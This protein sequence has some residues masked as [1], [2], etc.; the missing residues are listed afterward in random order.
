MANYRDF[1][2]EVAKTAEQCIQMLDNGVLAVECDGVV[3]SVSEEIKQKLDSSYFLDKCRALYLNDNK[4]GSTGALQLVKI[5]SPR[6]M[7]T[8]L[9]LGNNSIGRIGAEG[10]AEYLKSDST[11]TYLYLGENLIGDMAANAF[12]E[13]L[14]VNSTLTELNLWDNTIGEIGASALANCLKTNN[15]LHHFDIGKNQLG[16]NGAVAYAKALAVNTG[17]ICTNIS[18]NDIGVKGLDA[19]TEALKTNTT[20][21]A[22]HS[23]NNP[24]SGEGMK[25]YLKRNAVSQKKA[26]FTALKQ[27]DQ[28]APWRSAKLMIIGNGKAGKTATVRSLL[29]KPFNSNW[30][31]TVGVDLTR[32]KTKTYRTGWTEGLDR[33]SNAEEMAARVAVTKLCA[34]EKSKECST[35]K[36][37]NEKSKAQQSKKMKMS[38]RSQVEKSTLAIPDIKDAL[39]P[40]PGI[41]QYTETLLVQAKKERKCLKFSIWDY[42]GQEVFYTMHH[43]FLTQYGVYVLVFSLVDFLNDE[44]KCLEN[45]NFWLLSVQIH[46]PKAPIVIV[47][48][49]LDALGERTNLKLKTINNCLFS[50]IG[51]RFS[52]VVHNEKENLLFFPLNNK[53]SI[54]IDNVRVAIEKVTSCQEYVNRLVPIKWMH[55]LDAILKDKNCNFI[56]LDLARDIASQHG[57]ISSDEVDEMLHMFHE[58]GLIV[59][60]RSTEALR[61]MV[62]INPQWL[63][64]QITKVIRDHSIHKF[65]FDSEIVERELGADINNLITH[66]LAT[67]DLLDYLWPKNHVDYLLDLMRE[68][69]LISDWSFGKESKNL[70]LVPSLKD[71]PQ[72]QSPD[73]SDRGSLKGKKC[74]IDFSATLLPVGIFQR[75]VALLVAYSGRLDGAQ[76]PTLGYKDCRIWLGRESSL[77]LLECKEKIIMVVEDEKI[78]PNA[79]SVLLSMLRKLNEGTLKARLKWKLFLEVDGK[80]L[81]YEEAKA[82]VVKPWFEREE[83]YDPDADVTKKNPKVD[84]NGFFEFLKANRAIP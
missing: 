27:S 53:D 52:Q 14:K 65:D 50:A 33:A 8:Y 26:F 43:L 39:D 36:S 40:E 15:T 51:N 41:H 62:T 48:T 49:F 58:L 3:F 44:A 34:E 84:L 60:L 19:I 1:K 76:E 38:P 74:I 42:G 28:K 5:L 77:R 17:L 4:L 20:I 35:E 69:L 82:N 54:G 10:I 29:G 24:G 9:Y 75:L 25:K 37:D 80:C 16:D 22:V 72:G 12:G 61:N 73:G 56:S 66:G 78:L 2:W 32:T 79:L 46:A 18:S 13:A 83:K 71:R 31:S 23:L 55:F 59:H 70:Y 7:L 11:M 21:T 6:S 67:K 64:D 68:T 57:V 47:G 81:P 30:E 45:V 63:I